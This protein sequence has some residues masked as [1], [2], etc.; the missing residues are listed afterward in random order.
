MRISRGFHKKQEP[1]LLHGF[2]VNGSYLKDVRAVRADREV[3]LEQELIGLLAF[4]E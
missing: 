4:R 3:D 2:M 1:A